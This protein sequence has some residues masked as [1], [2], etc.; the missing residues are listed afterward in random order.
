MTIALQS[1]LE[2]VRRWDGFGIEPAKLDTTSVFGLAQFLSTL[3]LLVVVFNVTDFRYRYRLSVHR[4]DVKYVGII[5][6]TVLAGLLLLTELWFQNSLSLPHFLNNYGNI[7]LILAAVFITL[8]IYV[9]QACF[10]RHA[11]FRRS[12]A[13]QFFRATNHYI[14]Q[15]HK[16]RL[17]AI[18]EELTSIEDV[19]CAASK[20]PLGK[21]AEAPPI[22]QACA[23]DLL[24]TIADRRF[25]N[26]IVDRVPFFA[27]QCFALA[28]KYQNAPFSQF[29]RNIGEEF[30]VN[31]GSAFYQEDSGFSSGYFGYAK[32]I[33]GVV[34]GC[35]PLI[36]RC[37]ARDNASPLDLNYQVVPSLNATQMRGFTRAGLIFFESYLRETKAKEHSFAFAR[38]LASYKSSLSGLY[39]LR[40]STDVCDSPE[41]SRLHC[42][43]DFTKDAIKTIDKYELKAL[44]LKPTK[45]LRDYPLDAGTRLGYKYL[46]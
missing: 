37:A 13:E 41:L 31:T 27:I 34:F 40:N 8:V 24:L 32:P 20:I 22:H 21:A 23:H 10:L 17:Q 43:V 16:E 25:C 6:S 36:E 3:A 2:A 39:R 28:E 9:V 30:I 46:Q 1:A 5:I 11:T 19:F 14:H 35:F 44:S 26:V 33:T 7:K 12:N 42:V 45:S 15:G 38:L 29:S 18:A 4:F